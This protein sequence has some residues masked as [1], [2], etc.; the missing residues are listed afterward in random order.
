MKM[1]KRSLLWLVIFLILAVAGTIALRA[2]NRAAAAEVLRPPKGAKV[3]I[4][5]FEDLQCPD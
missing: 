5:V 3:A 2:Q 4:V 1:N